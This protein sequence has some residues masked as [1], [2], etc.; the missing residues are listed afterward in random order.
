MSNLYPRCWKCNTPY[1]YQIPRPWLIK[2]LLFFL[3]IK[4]YFCPH[5]VTAR[6]AWIKSETGKDY[7]DGENPMKTNDKKNRRKK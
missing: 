2:N 5:C 1:H 6:Y 7:L 3:P 4:K